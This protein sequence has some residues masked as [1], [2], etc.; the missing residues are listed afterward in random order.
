[1]TLDTVATETPAARATSAIFTRS[2]GYTRMMLPG[3]RPALD[4]VAEQP[5]RPTMAGKDRAGARGRHNRR[6]STRHQGVN[7][8]RPPAYRLAGASARSADAAHDQLDLGL[9]STELPREPRATH[10]RDVVTS[11]PTHDHSPVRI[12]SH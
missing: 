11:P 2:V 9:V 12:G 6:R 3:G 8:E 1:M 5:H 7:P 10:V 4:N